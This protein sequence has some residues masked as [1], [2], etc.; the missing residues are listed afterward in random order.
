MPQATRA[1]R[2]G[3]SRSRYAPNCKDFAGEVFPLPEELGKNKELRELFADRIPDQRR[4]GLVLY[5]LG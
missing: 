4:R 1:R 3:Y 2:C 5:P